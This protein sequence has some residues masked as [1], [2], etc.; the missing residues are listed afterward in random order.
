MKT[1]CDTVD[2]LFAMLDGELDTV[3]LTGNKYFLEGCNCTIVGEVIN[4]ND[5]NSFFLTIVDEDDI[6]IDV[7]S[8][9]NADAIDAMKVYIK[10]H[11]ALED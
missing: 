7:I 11:Y 8:C 4:R 5:T 10:E 6:V 9:D 2:T 3:N 1:V